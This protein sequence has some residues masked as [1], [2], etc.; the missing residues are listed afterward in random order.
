M[1]FSG[2]WIDKKVFIPREESRQRK[3]KDILVNMYTLG[4]AVKNLERSVELT[5]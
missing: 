4:R 3:T 2:K 5:T 1:K